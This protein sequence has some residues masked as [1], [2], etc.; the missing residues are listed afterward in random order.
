MTGADIRTWMPGDNLYNNSV[1]IPASLPDG[2]YQV[3]IAI[4]DPATREP[5]IKL[6]IQGMDA[7]GWY[8]LGQCDRSPNIDGQLR[9]KRTR[10]H[11]IRKLVVRNMHGG[12]IRKTKELTLQPGRMKR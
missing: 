1:F 8:A 12:K 6:A 7:D 5:A 9:P 11:R 4:V 10:L 3:S 2:E